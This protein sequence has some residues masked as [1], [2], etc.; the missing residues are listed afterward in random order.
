M[1]RNLQFRY[2]YWAA[3]VLLAAAGI[4]IIGSFL[5]LPALTGIGQAGSLTSR[6]VV[7]QAWQ[8]A[9]ELGSYHFS[10]NLE[11]AITATGQPVPENSARYERLYIEGQVDLP[12][13]KME[14]TMWEKGGLAFNTRQ[15]IQIKLEGGKTYGRV[16]SSDWQEMEDATDAFA[17][18]RDPM[19]YLAGARD[20]YLAGTGSVEVPTPEGTVV[21]NYTRYGFTVDGVRFARSL[22]SQLERQIAESGEIPPGVKLDATEAFRDLTGQG[23]VWI[24]EAGLPL[25]LIVDLKYP[26]QYGEQT[27]AQI[28]TDF[29][30]Y[31][32][33][34][35][36]A[37]SMLGRLMSWTQGALNLP[38]TGEAWGDFSLRASMLIICIAFVLIMVGRSRSRA[39]YITLAVVIILS[40][41]VSPIWE[42]QKVLAYTEKIQAQRQEA[43]AQQAFKQSQSSPDW[44]P[45]QDPLA[46]SE[47]SAANLDALGDPAQPLLTFGGTQTIG[48]GDSSEINPNSD[49]DGDGLTYQEEMRLGTDPTLL[50]SDLDELG[51]G[52]EV[53]GFDFLGDHYYTNPISSDTASD[54]VLD[55][56]ECWNSTPTTLPTNTAGCTLDSDNDGQLDIFE[57]DNDNDG[58][59]DSVDL[60]AFS[61]KDG[62]SSDNPFQLIV[63]KLEQKPVLVDLQ[64]RPTNPEH[65]AYTLSVLDWPTGDTQGQVQRV[66]NNTFA[67]AVD[68]PLTPEEIAADPRVQY[69]DMRLIPM[70]EISV[71]YMEGH[72]RNLPVKPGFTGTLEATTPLED[73]VDQDKLDKYGLST[74][75]LDKTGRLAIYAP[76]N[77]VTDETGGK[78]VAFQ[79]RIYYEPQANLD[80]G[81]AQEV[82]VIWWVQMLADQCDSSAY[83]ENTDGEFE[84][85]CA[86]PENRIETMQIVHTY[87]EQWS[88]TGF[89]VRE[90]HGLETIVAFEDPNFDG[91]VSDD[92]NLWKLANGMDSAFMTARDCDPL[93]PNGECK[94]DGLRDVTLNEIERRFDNRKNSNIPVGD[95]V[96][97]NIPNTALQV[98]KE[99]FPHQDYQITIVTTTTMQI[100]DSMFLPVSNCKLNC[101]IPRAAAPTLLYGTEAHARTAN[102][103]IGGI[104]MGWAGALL[105]VDMDPGIITL[106]TLATMSWSPFRY[107]SGEWEVYPLDEYLVEFDKRLDSAFPIDPSDPESENEV[108]T[109]KAIVASYYLGL[110]QGTSATVESGGVLNKSAWGVKDTAIVTS[111]LTEA[112][113]RT[114]S[115]IWGVIQLK[116]GSGVWK[117]WDVDTAWRYQMEHEGYGD[118]TKFPTGYMSSFVERMCAGVKMGTTIAMALVAVTFMALSLA[119][120]PPPDYLPFIQNGLM[121]LGSTVLIGISLF[122]MV[123]PYIVGGLGLSKQWARFKD[124]YHTKG[125]KL[126][127]AGFV[128]DIL[129]QTALFLYSMI[130]TGSEMSGIE[131]SA[132]ITYFIITIAVT[133]ILFAL[134]LIPVIGD[135]IAAVIALI[136]AVFN[137]VCAALGDDFKESW[138]GI[139]CKGIAGILGTILFK[140]IYSAQSMPYFPSED[141]APKNYGGLEQSSPQLSLVDPGEGFKTGAQLSYTFNLTRTIRLTT[142]DELENWKA[143]QWSFQ[144]NETNLKKTVFDYLLTKQEA[145]PHEGLYLG[146]EKNW[147]SLGERDSV[148]W[149]EIRRP[150]SN[151]QYFALGNAGI[152]QAVATYYNEGYDL[153]VQECWG[154]PMPPVSGCGIASE[155]DSGHSEIGQYFLYDVFPADLDGFRTLQPVT[156]GYRLTWGG[157][158]LAFLVMKDA[159][160][161]GLAAGSDPGD[162]TWDF[163]QDGLSDI[164]EL[165]Y[166]INPRDADSDHDTLGDRQE[167]LLGSDPNR[168]DSDNDGLTDKL[169]LEG[170]N[171]VYGWVDATTPKIIRVKSNPRLYDSDFDGLSD[172]KEW[173]YGWNPMAIS[174]GDVLTFSSELKEKEASGQ[175]STSDGVVRRNDVLRFEANVKNE[176]DLRYA[177]GLLSAQYP[178]GSLSGSVVP[179]TF[180]LAPRELA[181][182]QGDLSVTASSSGPLTLTQIAGAEL[183]NAQAISNYAVLLLHLEE[184]ADATTFLDEFRWGRAT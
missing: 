151:Q 131:I 2:R 30:G 155:A 87:P 104:T 92:D 160:G 63:S 57:T 27:Q 118:P 72:T 178:A 132:T 130:T 102:L 149:V 148:P 88:L 37:L 79:S 141:D 44:D 97:W 103:D 51:D 107:Q 180:V 64:I 135:I 140:A 55:T 111:N 77:L 100:L 126:A 167:L 142:Y 125:F 115:A 71:P 91:N 43:E 36:T 105:T 108:H 183:Y 117:K 122:S 13:Q 163:D 99:Q 146:K 159:D 93:D 145:D 85:W 169:E 147:V 60:S 154:W 10:T 5:W 162:G 184:A 41:L 119:L 69:G 175:Y 58:V 110:T 174:E 84:E 40:M 19:A 53:K 113:K 66:L 95:P 21:V 65:L 22:S 106:D 68:N 90:D 48:V 42:S 144:F 9:R 54:G 89:S 23:E 25:R 133:A 181:T 172:Q 78:N 38:A 45:Q 137:I 121:A 15:G 128:V 158:S 67:T 3:A 11:A 129:A 182:I 74:H 173:L 62:F 39:I 156:G 138:G 152:N 7:E 153:P 171:F 1:N 165:Q 20:I 17:P 164:Y 32:E 18:G 136:N 75:Y 47:A 4:L 31:P 35:A 177:R 114:F 134:T 124:F 101:N 29:S 176:L 81:N 33:T 70:L 157:S 16:G 83:D 166:G 56:L 143:R 59:A 86:R 98:W 76:L 52:L 139:I 150:L 73:W 168:A 50:N 8:R 94:G 123:K 82:R 120:D 34:S 170:W 161:D 24:D 28:E 14:L 46:E 12:A 179:N 96:L 61:A 49:D 127:V 26:E 116:E 112:F 6:Q 109:Q 80:W